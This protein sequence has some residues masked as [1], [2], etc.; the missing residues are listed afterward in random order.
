MRNLELKVEIYNSALIWQSSHVHV[1]ILKSRKRRINVETKSLELIG[2]LF[3]CS[4]HF[5]LFSV[6]RSTWPSYYCSVR[7][8]FGRCLTTTRCLLQIYVFQLH[9][10]KSAGTME[11]TSADPFERNRVIFYHLP[12]IIS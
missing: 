8:N 9:K 7:I 2:V 4:S 10:E 12:T 11:G 5:C 1:V 3:L 6:M